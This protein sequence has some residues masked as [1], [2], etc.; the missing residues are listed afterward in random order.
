MVSHSV[1]LGSNRELQFIGDLTNLCKLHKVSCGDS[2]DLTHLSDDLVSNEKFR[3]DLFALCTAISHMGTADLSSEQ[4]LTL[5]AR[6]VAGSGISVSNTDLPQEARSAFIDGYETWSKR[7]LEVEFEPWP[8]DPEPDPLPPLPGRSR[9]FAAAARTHAVPETKNG[10]PNYH[11]TNGASHHHV[12]GNTPLENLTLSELRMYL[13]D[14]ENRVR[15]IEPHLEQIA[16]Q[17]LA[18]DEAIAPIEPQETSSEPSITHS[19]D[20]PG[21]A[22]TPQAI[23]TIPSL[24]LIPTVSTEPILDTTAS[25]LMILPPQNVIL[26]DHQSVVPDAAP[27][28]RLRIIN[29]IL[30]ILLIVVCGAGAIF[31]WRYLRPLPASATDTIQQ[32]PAPGTDTS[33]KPSPADP[34]SN[35]LQQDNRPA[36]SPP[37]T[38]IRPTGTITAADPPDVH[39]QSS[40]PQQTV[41]SASVPH[42]QVDTIKAELPPIQIPETTSPS[43][44]NKP[45]TATPAPIPQDHSQAASSPSNSQTDLNKAEQKRAAETHPVLVSAATPA[46]S[47]PADTPAP[48]PVA[49][50]AKPTNP[51]IAV[52]PAMIM[53]YAVSTPKPTYPRYRHLAMDTTI[54]VQTTISKDGK[55]V[56]AR[57]LNGALDVQDAVV[58]AVQTWRFRPYIVSGNPVEVSTTFKFVFKAP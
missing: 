17:K 2:R 4:L 36:N 8:E 41:V 50:P 19:I 25:S 1:L 10:S 55:I 46:P 15:R 28:R 24:D 22:T 3:L 37:A 49:H 9:F 42:A 57:A 7:E 18:P 11:A 31:A 39:P 16:P 14:I 35:V 58:K 21:Q 51:I 20:E 23:E 5:V 26:P 40:Q 30:T 29:A 33:S 27:L 56:S 54:D 43:Y 45:I 47:R 38:R 52:P 48:S 53:T 44:V 6:A 32:V 34:T 13:E 12:P